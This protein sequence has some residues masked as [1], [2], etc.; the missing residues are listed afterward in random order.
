MKETG[1]DWKYIKKYVI[2]IAKTLIPIFFLL[3]YQAKNSH[4][5]ASTAVFLANNTIALRQKVTPKH[6]RNAPKEL[7]TRI[8]IPII[9]TSKRNLKIKLFMKENHTIKK[10]RN[11]DYKIR[12]WM[13]RKGVSHHWKIVNSQKW[14]KDPY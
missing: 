11:L 14:P 8:K 4:H 6:T 2:R 1:C 13:Q 7:L 12:T 10:I 3:K 9:N 5:E